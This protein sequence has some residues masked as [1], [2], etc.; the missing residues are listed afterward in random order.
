[1]LRRIAEAA[2]MMMIQLWTIVVFG[3]VDNTIAFLFL[4]VV[5]SYL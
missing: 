5:T 1:M 4:L 3:V 2:A